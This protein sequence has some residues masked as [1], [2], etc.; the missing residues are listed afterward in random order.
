M[1]GDGLLGMLSFVSHSSSFLRCAAMNQ[2]VSSGMG[3]AALLVS[4]TWEVMNTS[5]CSSPISMAPAF[6]RT[7]STTRWGRLELNRKMESLGKR[8]NLK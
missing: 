8:Q 3:L 1:F 2:P 5:V 7:W 6:I 4:L